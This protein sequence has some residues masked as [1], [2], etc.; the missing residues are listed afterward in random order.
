MS[1][2]DILSSVDLAIRILKQAR[3]ES[4]NGSDRIW[5]FLNDAVTHL[6]KEIKA[7]LHEEVAA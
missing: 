6:D 4:A 3:F 5:H 2:V 1:T 7:L